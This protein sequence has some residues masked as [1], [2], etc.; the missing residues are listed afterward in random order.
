QIPFGLQFGYGVG[1]QINLGFG[2]FQLPAIRLDYGWSAWNPGGKFYFR[3][4]FPF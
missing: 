2:G 3:L 1:L 4:G